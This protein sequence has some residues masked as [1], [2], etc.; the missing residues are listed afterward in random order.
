MSSRTPSCNCQK[1]SKCHYALTYDVPHIGPHLGR[2]LKVSMRFVVLPP[3]GICNLRVI[4][5]GKLQLDTGCKRNEIG[6][7]GI[8]DAHSRV[9]HLNHVPDY[10]AGVNHGILMRLLQGYQR[11]LIMLLTGFH[12]QDERMM[13]GVINI[14]L[15]IVEGAL[16]VDIAWPNIVFA[17]TPRQRSRDVGGAHSE[18]DEEIRPRCSGVGEHLFEI[19]GVWG[20]VSFHSRISNSIRRLSM[21]ACVESFL[22]KGMSADE[23]S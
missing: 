17:S 20:Q 16:T 3:G 8:V 6:D 5:D 9:F 15:S 19:S 12:E 7:E 23:P 11:N 10:P 2:R 13:P 22:Q 4:V 21:V 18:H 1:K 14:R